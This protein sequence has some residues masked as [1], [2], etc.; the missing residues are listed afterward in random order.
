[1]G[2]YFNA[3]DALFMDT[4]ERFEIDAGRVY[5]SGFS[6]GSRAALAVAVITKK[7]QGVIACGAGFPTAPS[8]KPTSVDKFV[9]I[10]LVGNKDMNYSEHHDVQ[11]TLNNLN[12]ENELLVFEGIHEWPPSKTIVKALGWLEV[13]N[14]RHHGQRPAEALLS[15]IRQVS[16]KEAQFHEA[17]GNLLE[18]IASYEFAINTLKPHM[19]LSDLQKTLAIHRQNK[20]YSKM[21]KQKQKTDKKE[22]QLKEKYI[23]VFTSSL[24]KRLNSGSFTSDILNLK[25]KTIYKVWPYVETVVGS[26]EGEAITFATD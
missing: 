8:Y 21:L 23:K 26:V 7:V 15:D 11:Q 3:A 9:Y 20:A 1:M 19:N 22:L 5:T 17:N 6:G 10:G 12:I 16:I 25:S 24:G 14:A 18:A 2:S 4:F 13:Q